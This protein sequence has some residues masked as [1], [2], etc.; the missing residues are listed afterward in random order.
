MTGEAAIVNRAMRHEMNIEMTSPR[1]RPIIASI[2]VETVSVVRP[3]SIATSSDS[4][5]VKMPGACYSA[6]NQAT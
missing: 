2:S 6:S 3:F 4:K 5:L 1:N